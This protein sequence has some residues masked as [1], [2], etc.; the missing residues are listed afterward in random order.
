MKIIAVNKLSKEYK[1]KVTD[2]MKGFIYNLFNEKEK[3]VKAVNNISFS[4]EEGETVAFIG[5]LRVIFT[6]VVPSL[7]L[8]AIPVEIVKNI[9]LTNLLMII[10]LTVF[11]FILAV[12]FFYKS[13]KKYESNNL[14]GFGN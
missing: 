12:A 7:L 11:W 4:V 9:S 10:L 3:V 5:L 1:Y 13:L 8:G 14:F 6:F 2:E